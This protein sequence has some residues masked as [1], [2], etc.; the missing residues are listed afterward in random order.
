LAIKIQTQQ[1]GIPIEIGALTFNFDTTDES[2]FSF[3]QKYEKVMEEMKALDMDK[4]DDA[5]LDD[6]KEVLRR[7]Y[8]LFLGEG[9]FEKVYE[10]TP[11]VFACLQYYKQIGQ[12][13]EEELS[14]MTKVTQQEKTDKYLNTKQKQNFNKQKQ[15]NR[16]R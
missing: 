13:I 2:I 14:A 10:Q 6:V 8:S 4:K 12:G 5:N 16:K 15:N 7:G 9:A 11:S 3:Q 1:T